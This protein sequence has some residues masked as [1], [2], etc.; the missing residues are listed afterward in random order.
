MKEALHWAVRRAGVEI[1]PDEVWVEIER[2]F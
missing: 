2:G 1:V